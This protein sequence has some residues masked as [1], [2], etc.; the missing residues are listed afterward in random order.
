MKERLPEKLI[1][2]NTI[3]FKRGRESL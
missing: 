2:I 3:A 1:E